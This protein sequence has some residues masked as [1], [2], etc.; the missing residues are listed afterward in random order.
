MQ[1]LG[2]HNAI[3]RRQLIIGAAAA[4]SAAPLLGMGRILGANDRINLAIIGAGNMGLRHLHDRLLPLAKGNGGIEIVAACDVYE[5]A[6]QRA[7]ALTG[8]QRKDIYNDYH[9][10]LGRSDIDAVLIASPEH[11]H[12]PMAMAALR[13]G[14]DIYLEKPMTY[15]IE[16]AKEIAATVHKT[17]RVLQVG[18]Q[19]ASDPRYH[20]AREVIQKGW[21]GD[22]LGAQASWGGDFQHGLWEYNIE[23]EATEKTVDWKAWLGPAPDRPFSA[24]RYFRW[25]KYWD[26]SGGIGTDLFYHELTPLIYAMGPQFPARVS[27]NGG[28]FFSLDREV[29]DVYIMTAEY[30]KF[31]VTLS[32]N[33]A[34]SS[35][36][37]N[38]RTVIFGREAT[39]S[40]GKTGI[41]VHP[42]PIF[43]TKFEQ[44]TN[45]KELHLEPEPMPTDDVR[46]LH[47]KNFFSSVRSRQQPALDA[48]LGYK[49]MTA[50]KLG[51]DSYR[52][53]RMM[54]F[55]PQTEQAVQQASARPGYEG[56]GENYN[57]PG[58]VLPDG[59][60]MYASWEAEGSH[61]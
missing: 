33:S 48:D 1:S 6:R 8:L 50:I 18:S 41:D 58:A 12:H 49:V 56:T 35:L 42:E 11:Q 53:S 5:K 7:Q 28:I 4:V 45:Q 19:Y 14:K 38:F 51:V 32:A 34:C 2:N 44:A 54:L 59:R 40:F 31:Q 46:M 21:I 57:E 3:S 30:D 47:M 20:L 23:P 27:A 13:A 25:R 29:P 43:R 9:E 24:E 16:E 52:Q 10:M 17:H 15:S 60:V 55:D 36:G 37:G 26:Y 39:I 61:S 22:V